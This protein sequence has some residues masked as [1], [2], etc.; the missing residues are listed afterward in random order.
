M[1]HREACIALNM[2]P[3]MGPVKMRRLLE[4]FGSAERILAARPAQ[5]TQ[6]NGI[7][8]ELAKNISDWASHADPAAEEKKARDLGAHVITAMV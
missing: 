8:E 1:N 5:L 6:V 3:Q 4:A 7:G 2:V